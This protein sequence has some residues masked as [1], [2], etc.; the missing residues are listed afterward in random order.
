MIAPITSIVYVF[1]ENT[2]SLT[3]QAQV[4]A[5]LGNVHWSFHMITMHMNRYH[6]V[7]ESMEKL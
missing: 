5:L 7:M 1:F 6:D 4:G 2:M 3:L